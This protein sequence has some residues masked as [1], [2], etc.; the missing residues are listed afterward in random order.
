MRD[1]RKLI[2][3]IKYRQD[4]EAANEL[5]SHYYQEIFAYAF[6]Q[7]GDQELAMDL[8][9]EIFCLFCGES[10]DL[11]RERRDFEPGCTVSLPTE[12]QTITAAAF[13]GRGDGRCRCIGEEKQDDR[14]LEGEQGG[15]SSG[16]ERA[17]D[18]LWEND[19]LSHLLR[20]EQIC[21]VM[22]LAAGYDR[23]WVLIFQRKI[24]LEHSFREI[25]EDLGIRN[26]PSRPDIIR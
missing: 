21:R 11:T 26:L 8:T 14:Y 23:A 12:L 2:R 18:K 17:E 25:A 10:G 20:K 15:G 22:E 9:Q 13:T 19:V 7:T 3:N 6:R 4:R 24:F 5:I 1:E 16:R